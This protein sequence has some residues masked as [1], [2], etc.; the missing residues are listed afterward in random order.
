MRKRASMLALAA[1]MTTA[2]GIG[3]SAHADT[4]CVDYQVT[5]PIVGTRSGRPCVTLGPLYDFPFSFHDCQ[6][7]PPLRVSECVGA[8]LHLPLP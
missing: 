7:I 5:A 6:G 8:D 1:A 2:L 4:E 3:A